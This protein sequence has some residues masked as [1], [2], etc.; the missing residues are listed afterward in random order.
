MRA[1]PRRLG[2]YG[3]LTVL[4]LEC[5]L[6]GSRPASGPALGGSTTGLALQLGFVICDASGRRWLSHGKQSR[7]DTAGGGGRA[8]RPHREPG[9]A[10]SFPEGRSCPGRRS[11]RRASGAAGARAG[12]D[13]CGHAAHAPARRARTAARPGLPARRSD[14]KG[15]AGRRAGGPGASAAP[16][17]GPGCGRDTAQGQPGC[18]AACSG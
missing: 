5:G 12:A 13:Q 16:L 1:R 17:A 7:G 6:T 9:T 18:G 8:A 2:F 3:P 15:G 4:R 14:G 10:S 11:G